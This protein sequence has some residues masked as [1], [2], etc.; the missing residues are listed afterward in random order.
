M[1]HLFL[2]NGGLINILELSKIDILSFLV[3]CICHDLGHDGYTNGYHVNAQ[4][5]RAIRYNDISVQENY[6]A[7]ETFVILQKPMFNFLGGKLSN[8]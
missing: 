5:D 1:G 4:T 3:A 6:H 8:E 2:T 7:A